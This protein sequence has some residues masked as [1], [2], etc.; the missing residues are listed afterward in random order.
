MIL[1]VIIY[2]YVNQLIYAHDH[3]A[4]YGKIAVS[5]FIYEEELKMK[6]GKIISFL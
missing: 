5:I 2:I 1:K 6:L 3:S 4:F